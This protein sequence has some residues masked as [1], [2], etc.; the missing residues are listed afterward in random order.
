MTFLNV[1]KFKHSL[2]FE[3]TWAIFPSVIILLILIPSMLLLYSLD[4]E[5]DPAFSVRVVGHQ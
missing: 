4:E 2:F 3:F 5:L 1:R